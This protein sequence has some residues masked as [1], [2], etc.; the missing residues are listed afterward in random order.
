MT[1]NSSAPDSAADA[2]SLR[3]ALDAACQHYA[4]VR[5]QDIASTGSRFSWFRG[6]PALEQAESAYRNALLA[7]L[8]A[9][10][11]GEAIAAYLQSAEAFAWQQVTCL[12][13]GIDL[14][15][16]KPGRNF[17]QFRSDEAKVAALGFRTVPLRELRNSLAFPRVS[18]HYPMAVF[19]QFVVRR[20]PGEELVLH[21]E[22]LLLHSPRAASMVAVA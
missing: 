20:A 15:A 22:Q 3:Q 4:T 11:E 16:G 21:A 13:M 19:A 6:H 7:L 10:P 9:M 1:H 5:L 14:W 2:S 8:F 18:H 12:S 17:L